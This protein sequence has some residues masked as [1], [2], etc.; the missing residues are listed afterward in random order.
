MHRFR[1]RLIRECKTRL[2]AAKSEV[3]SSVQ[4]KDALSDGIDRKGDFGDR[5]EKDNS[6]HQ[7]LEMQNRLRQRL[8]EIESALARIEEGSYGICEETNEYIEEKRLLALPWTRLS[9]EGAE[10]LEHH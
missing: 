3:L 7:W 9:L 10:L 6:Q 1:A 8:F 2:L 4:K 5:S